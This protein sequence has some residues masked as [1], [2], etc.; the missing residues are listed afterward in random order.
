MYLDINT[1]FNMNLNFNFFLAMLNIIFINIILSGDNAVLIAMAVRHLPNHNRM[2]GI[3][4]GTTL[5]VALRIVLT[6]FVALLME[7]SFLKIVGGLL[8]L[9]IAVKLLT[10]ETGDDRVQGTTSLW[11]AVQ[12]ILIADLTMSIDNVLAVAGAAGGNLP[13]LIFG[14]CL[15]IP[16]VVFASQ[17][18]SSLMERYPIIVVIGAAILGRVGV[19]MI[20]TDP[21]MERW[22]HPATALVYFIQGLGMMGVVLAGKYIR[23]RRSATA[24]AEESIPEPNGIRLEKELIQP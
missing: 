4:F 18:L 5:A 19:D 15:S 23:N 9:W 6:F 20:M 22:L 2:K 7:V 17:I 10:E 16:I 1:I 11:K 24:S 14:L 8:I 3:A 12:V 21:A 13:L